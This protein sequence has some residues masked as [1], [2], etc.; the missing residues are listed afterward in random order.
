MV[1]RGGLEARS[2]DDCLE[3]RRLVEQRRLF[4]K[5][6]GHELPPSVA[7]SWSTSPRS[8]G[9]IAASLST[10]STLVAAARAGLDL[11]AM[12]ANGVV[13]RLLVVVDDVVAVFDDVRLD[14][15]DDDVVLTW[16]VA[17]KHRVD[18]VAVD[19][20]DDG[21]PDDGVHRDGAQVRA[22]AAGDAVAAPTAGVERKTVTVARAD[23]ALVVLD[24]CYVMNV[25]VADDD[26]V[27][28]EVVGRVDGDVSVASAAERRRARVAGG[29]RVDTVGVGRN[30]DTHDSRTSQTGPIRPSGL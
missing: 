22:H 8:P 25:A 30:V 24:E 13:A 9:V 3:E 11:V 18:R 5:A 14:V 20:G 1:E 6:A 26:E 21:R 10:S 4:A 16:R 17:L 29:E 23:V 28:P 15:V 27:A 7:T 2:G 12:F 19:L